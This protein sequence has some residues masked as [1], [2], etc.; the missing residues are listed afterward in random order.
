[1]LVVERPVG[2]LARVLRLRLALGGVRRSRGGGGI[3]RLFQWTTGGAREG[4]GGAAGGSLLAFV[5]GVLGRRRQIA[6]LGDEGGQAA[7][8]TVR[9]SY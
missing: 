1:M 7:G 5:D 4:P 3:L 2:H 6:N 9:R 8:D